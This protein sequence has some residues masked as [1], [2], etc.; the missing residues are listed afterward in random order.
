[1]SL[2]VQETAAARLARIDPYGL[3][4]WPV[5]HP[6]EH[7]GAC[8]D[9]PGSS[10]AVAEAVRAYAEEMNRLNRDR[11]VQAQ[12][13]RKVLAKVE[14]A[15]AGIIAAIEDGMYQPSM[16]ARMDDLER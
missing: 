15:I 2:A 9:R 14:K 7:R 4:Q 11:R 10:E 1:M 13:D 5:H 12:T 8:A 6:P 16:K 3:R